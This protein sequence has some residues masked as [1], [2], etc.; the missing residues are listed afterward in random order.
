[1]SKCKCREE[2]TSHLDWHTGPRVIVCDACTITTLRS[3]VEALERALA[4][5]LPHMGIIGC[6]PCEGTGEDEE[7]VQCK[8]CNGA[9]DLNWL[10]ALPANEAT[11]TATAG[12]E[13][14]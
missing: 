11:G 1:M 4:T 2:Y 14:V 12:K 7:G 10:L 9:G 5:T 6:R 8:V 13:S 3:R